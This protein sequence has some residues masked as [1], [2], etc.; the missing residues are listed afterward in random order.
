VNETFKWQYQNTYDEVTG[1]ANV[2]ITKKGRNIIFKIETEEDDLF[3]IEG[4]IK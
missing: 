2:T 4:T 1:V 3:K